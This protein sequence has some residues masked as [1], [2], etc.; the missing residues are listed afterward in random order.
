MSNVEELFQ[1]IKK[2]EMER[3]LYVHIVEKELCV[4]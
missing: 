3:T 4:L 2:C 1:R